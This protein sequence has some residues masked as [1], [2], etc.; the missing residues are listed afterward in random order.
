[1]FHEAESSQLPG[2]LEGR[3]DG[4]LGGERDEGRAR[5]SAV[6]VDPGAGVSQ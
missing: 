3:Q 2:Q 4:I 1:M 6:R 5:Q